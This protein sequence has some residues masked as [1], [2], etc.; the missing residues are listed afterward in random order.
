[1]E[2]SIHERSDDRWRL[3]SINTLTVYPVLLPDKYMGL[4]LP[5]YFAYRA[6]KV[7]LTT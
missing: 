6:E 5:P 1:M 7:I 4:F 3:P 2:I